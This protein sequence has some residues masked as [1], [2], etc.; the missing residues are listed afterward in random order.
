MQSEEKRGRERSEKLM[1]HFRPVFPL[2][3]P[4]RRFREFGFWEERFDTTRAINAQIALI[5]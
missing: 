4:K 5:F 2:T 3:V 1:K